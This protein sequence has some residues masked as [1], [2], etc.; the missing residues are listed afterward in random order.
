MQCAR[1]PADVMWNRRLTKKISVIFSQVFCTVFLFCF[2]FSKGRLLWCKIWT[3]ASAEDS[4]E[5]GWVSATSCQKSNHLSERT[6]WCSESHEGE[7]IP[8][9]KQGEKNISANLVITWCPFRWSFKRPHESSS[10]LHWP[11]QWGIFSLFITV[12]RQKG[13]SVF[14][15]FLSVA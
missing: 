6:Q 11:S 3:T 9:K 12:I 4:L 8:G 7:K 10:D 2:V 13:H 1:S 15:R 5:N 14:S